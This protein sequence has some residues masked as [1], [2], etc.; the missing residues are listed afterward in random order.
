M[1]GQEDTPERWAVLSSASPNVASLL[2]WDL[3]SGTYVKR[4]EGEKR[5]LLR[6]ADLL[7]KE[8]SR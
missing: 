5:D 3:F 7:N 1:S 2:E 4:G 8:A 6:V